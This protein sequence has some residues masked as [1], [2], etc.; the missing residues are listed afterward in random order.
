MSCLSPAGRNSNY[1]IYPRKVLRRVD[2]QLVS[3]RRSPRPKGAL[4][5]K[6]KEG[7]G[8][9]VRVGDYRILYTIDDESRIVTIYRVAHR[10]DAYR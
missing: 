10:R 8:W 2:R 1:E 7:E 9:R 5:L 4:M 6:G 3:L